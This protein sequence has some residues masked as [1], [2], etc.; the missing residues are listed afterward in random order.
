MI[1]NFLIKINVEILKNTLRNKKNTLII[2]NS[3]DQIIM[4]LN[5]KDL[6]LKK[7]VDFL[8]NLEKEIILNLPDWHKVRFKE[9]Y[10]KNVKHLAAYSVLNDYFIFIIPLTSRLGPLLRAQNFNDRGNIG[11]IIHNP[12][13]QQD[14][15]YAG[16][17]VENDFNFWKQKDF[18]LNSYGNVDFEMFQKLLLYKQKNISPIGNLKYN[19]YT[20]NYVPQHPSRQELVDYYS[21]KANPKNLWD[22]SILTKSSFSLNESIVI[23][24]EL[25][26]P[27][28]TF[29]ENYIVVKQ[30]DKNIT[31]EEAW[32]NTIEMYVLAPKVF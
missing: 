17:L 27:T 29:F 25:N 30:H 1:F 14:G 32:Q 21:K 28:R 24:S 15:V 18:D 8:K 11:V 5:H 2:E 6:V 19:A 9:I 12:L 23:Q 3:G 20:N 22:L 13:T 10:I 26:L 4:S 31:F 16:Y 7:N